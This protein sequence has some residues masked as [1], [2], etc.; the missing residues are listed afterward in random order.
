VLIAGPIICVVVL[1]MGMPGGAGEVIRI[2]GENGKFGFG[3]FD[4]SL[5][6]QTF[7]LVVLNAI[8]EHMRNWG[9]DQ[10]YVQRYISARSDTEARKSIWIAGLLYMPVG[11]FFFFIGSALFAFYKVQPDLLPAT[12]D[13]AKDPDAVFPYFITHQLPAGLSGLVIAAIFAASMDTNLNSMA[14]LSLHDVYKRYI[15]PDADDR[16]SLRV[17][18]A[19]TLFWGLMCVLFALV[20]TLKIGPTID[21]GWKVGGLLGGGLL[22][23]FLLGLLTRAGNRGAIAGTLAGVVVIVWMTLSKMP[24]WPR[25]W[26]AAANPLHDLAIPV[27][28]TVAVLVV[29]TL[30]GAAGRR[31]A[32]A[33]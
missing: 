7:W 3:P 16:Q 28:G 9:V 12:M 10:S 33:G 23:L 6:H 25:A 17:L 21:F 32:R 2:A 1:M 14:T 20:M 31:P 13:V 29:G 18:Y 19:A 22:G 24:V 4:A 27:C 8:I 26:A 15:R 5:L 11:F 30:M